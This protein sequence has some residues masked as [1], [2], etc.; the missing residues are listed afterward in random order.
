[1]RTLIAFFVLCGMA[2]ADTFVWMDW[3]PP[4]QSAIQI[5]AQ[6]TP[7]QSLAP[8]PPYVAPAQQSYQAN[9]SAPYGYTIYNGE[10]RAINPTCPVHGLPEYRAP[11]Q[12]CASGVCGVSE[13]QQQPTYIISDPPPSYQ[14]SPCANGQCPSGN[15][16]NCQKATTRPT[17]LPWNHR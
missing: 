3:V 9:P 4:R 14:S 11:A 6:W 17:L 10:V 1:M 13:S 2:S 5:S 8:I 16:P 15:C 7:T 12:S